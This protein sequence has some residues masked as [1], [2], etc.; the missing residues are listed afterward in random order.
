MGIVD[1]V[2]TA[3]EMYFSNGSRD[4]ASQERLERSFFGSI[5]QKNGTY[6]YTY[7]RRLDDLNELVAKLL[8]I[9]RPLRIMDVA[10]SSGAIT[11]E[12]S[13]MLERIG[14]VHTM[15]ASD[16]N[17]DAYLLSFLPGLRVLVD[18]NGY[19]LQYDIF[20]RPLMNPPLWWQ[21]GLYLPVL[22]PL[23]ACLRLVFGPARAAGIAGRLLP[24]RAIKLVSP[25]LLTNN[26][27][28]LIEDDITTNDSI[29]KTYQIV[30]ASNILNRSYFDESTLV[31]ILGNLRGRLVEGGLLVI[32]STTGD[33][34][35]DD[36]TSISNDGS[37]FALNASGQFKLVSRIGAGSA[38][39]DLVLGL[40]PVSPS[41]PY[42]VAAAA[43]LGSRGGNGP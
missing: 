32:C 34:R 18:R 13:R 19:P 36:Q 22:L 28:K 4:A 29:H 23:R 26:R 1:R 12:W 20:G 2:P 14:V 41:D 35:R 43:G 16:I 5:R 9:Q 15:T 30:R 8:P 3:R 33:L 25:A 39:E 7:S 40:G 11:L 38:V 31:R 24:C 10:V 37:I 17:L 6:K 21:K 27:I 42:L